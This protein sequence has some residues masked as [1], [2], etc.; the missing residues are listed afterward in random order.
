[1]FHCKTILV[2]VDFSEHSRL[3]FRIAA[4]LAR[5]SGGRLLVLHV[6]P[7]TGPLVAY[8]NVVAQLQTGD[9]EAKLRHAVVQF[10]VADET[11]AVEHHIRE[12]E[13]AAEILR[14]AHEA[15][16]ELIVMGSHGRTGLSRLMMGS[17]A[18][19]V[20]RKAHCPVLTAKA[21]S[22]AAMPVPRCDHLRTTGA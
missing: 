5:A 10:R 21:P 20:M 8:G 22:V 14:L 15:R 3:A 11:V 16:C 12:G 13:A 4:S 17:V 6:A 9:Y 7:H 1:M 19:Q 18:E 2:P